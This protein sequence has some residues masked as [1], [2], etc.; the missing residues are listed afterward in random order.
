MNV[1]TLYG[2]DFENVFFKTDGK[3][4]T[5]SMGDTDPILLH[6]RIPLEKARTVWE[7]LARMGW[8]SE[9]QLEAE[10]EASEWDNK[11]TGGA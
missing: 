2:N 10:A 8:K 4:C 3:V 5:I 1:Y 11:F 9:K 6:K 7:T